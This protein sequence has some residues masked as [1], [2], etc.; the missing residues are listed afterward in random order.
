[1]TISIIGTG[2]MARGIATRMIAGSHNV[3]LHAHNLTKGEALATELGKNAKAVAVGSE[4]H[5]IVVLAIPYDAISDVANQY[6][7]FAGKTVIDITNPIDF[8]TFQLIPEAGTSGAE[9][10]A[11]SLPDAHVIKA[12]NT[13][14]AG[15]L[16]AGEAGGFPLDVFIAGDDTAAKQAIAELVRDGGMRPIDTG[17]LQ[18]AR[19]LEGIQLIHMATQDQLGGGW[20]SA[21]TFVK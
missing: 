11:K 7:N 4:L 18:N 21:I 12:F 19:H 2:N 14:L 13:T 16:A 3:E 20:M 17:A 9:A 6:D 10:I 1:M 5:D 8:A 15:T